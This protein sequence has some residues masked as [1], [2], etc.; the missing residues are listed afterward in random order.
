MCLRLFVSLKVMFPRA[1]RKVG[2]FT[3]LSGQ[4]TGRVYDLCMML[5]S[6]DV[7]GI[8]ACHSILK[9]TFGRMRKDGP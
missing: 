6:E 7:G 4:K 9:R 8:I 5:A 2:G 1:T 3:I